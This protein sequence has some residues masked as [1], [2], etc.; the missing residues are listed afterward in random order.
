MQVSIVTLLSLS[1]WSWLVDLLSNSAALAGDS[2]SPEGLKEVSKLADVRL[3]LV[4][5]SCKIASTD[6]MSSIV[7]AGHDRHHKR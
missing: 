6:S 2:S 1:R 4:S 7:A 3:R 5:A